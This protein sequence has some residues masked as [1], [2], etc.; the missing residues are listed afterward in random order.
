MAAHLLS[1]LKP[2]F[3]KSCAGLAVVDDHGRVHLTDRGL[4][5]L[6]ARGRA[7]DLNPLH[8]KTLPDLVQF[9]T[10]LQREEAA[11]ATRAR[12]FGLQ[13]PSLSPE[14]RAFVRAMLGDVEPQVLKGPAAQP[15]GSV[16][17]LQ[18]WKRKRTARIDPQG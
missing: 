3:W 2:S 15:A 5:E 9:M 16:V 13:D 11:Q 1:S 8:C 4:K 7:Y 14:N 10:A 12:A 17:D 6:S 18:A